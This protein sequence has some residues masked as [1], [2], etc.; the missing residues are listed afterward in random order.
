MVPSFRYEKELWGKGYRV[1][2][3]SDEVGRGAWAGPV[4]ASAVAFA[5]GTQ[6]AKRKTQNQ[7]IM[8]D[9]SKKLRPGQ[10]E[11]AEKW[12]KKNALCWGIG[13]APVSVINR[14]GMAKASKMAF[15]K[16]IAACKRN[17]ESGI[18]NQGSEK[19]TIHNSKYTIQYLLIDAFYLP[20]TAGLP[21]G[22]RKRLTRTHP[23]NGRQLAIVNGDEKCF[24]I[25]AASIL[26]KVYRDKIMQGLSRR[27]P[28]YGWGRNKGY[29]TKEHQGAIKKHGLTRLHRKQ[30]I[31]GLISESS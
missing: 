14:L 21:I 1:V 18:R 22:K 6:N 9:D 30:F 13:E 4:V 2:V 16:A 26:A 28:K 11:K 3:G 27:H 19:A 24:S 8:I 17:L 12:I 10:R 20:Y 15:R 23:V 7:K 31:R 5:P 29:G 25:A